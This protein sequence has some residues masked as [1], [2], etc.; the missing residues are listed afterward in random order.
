[1]DKTA[2]G[3]RCNPVATALKTVMQN[4]LL[5]LSIHVTTNTFVERFFIGN[6]ISPTAY[7]NINVA[8]QAIYDDKSFCTK[9]NN[10]V[11]PAVRASFA[12]F[13]FLSNTGQQFLEGNSH[14]VE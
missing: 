10:Q 2:I 3:D 12:A 5:R 1:M 11:V 13:F 8:E 4:N 9:R 6:N 14:C 7:V